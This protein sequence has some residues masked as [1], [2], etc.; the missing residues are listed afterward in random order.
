[1]CVNPVL[2]VLSNVMLPTQEALSVLNYVANMVMAWEPDPKLQELSMH[3][4]SAH[5]PTNKDWP[6]SMALKLLQTS[7]RPAFQK[8]R[9][10]FSHMS[11]ESEGEALAVRIRKY[12]PSMKAQVTN[13][14]FKKEEELYPGDT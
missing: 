11:N 9:H 5:F 2:S 1:M 14:F 8:H 4:R 6:E 10:H 3:T 7:H 12:L 13:K